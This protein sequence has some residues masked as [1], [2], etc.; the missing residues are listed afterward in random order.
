MFDLF[1]GLPRATR[2]AKAA[3]TKAVWSSCKASVDR[4]ANPASQRRRAVFFSRRHCFA[5]SASKAVSQAAPETVCILLA[6][7]QP[8]SVYPRPLGGKG[9]SASLRQGLPCRFAS[10]VMSLDFAPAPFYQKCSIMC[11]VFIA[12]NGSETCSLSSYLRASLPA[13]STNTPS[14]LGEIYSSAPAAFGIASCWYLT[15][16]SISP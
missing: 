13:L 1:C 3:T 16:S 11:S 15:R 9:Y 8:A 2:A 10:S 7:W 5:E 6:G 4:T 12:L 14:S